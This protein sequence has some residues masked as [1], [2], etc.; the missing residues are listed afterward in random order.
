MAGSAKKKKISIIVQARMSSTR[1]PGKVLMEVC[2]KPALQHLIERLKFS[3]FAGQIILAI[4]DTQENDVL[5]KFAFNNSVG[6]YRGSENDVLGRIYLA[7]KKNNCDI[8]VEVTGDNPLIDPEIVDVAVKKH[9]KTNADYSCT[10]YKS[11]FLPIGL[12]VG[13]ISFQALEMAYRDAKE[14]Y[15]R[16]HVT[17]Y[18]YENPNIFKITG[19]EISKHLKGDDIRLTLDTKED[20]ELITKIFEKLYKPGRIFGAKEMLDLLKI[21]PELKKIN[22]HIIQKTR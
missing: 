19:I 12:D 5:E 15:N 10:N 3:K 17:S 13:V 2:G 14:V 22:S 21:E 9:I 7:S 16:E 18:F 11:K 4:P 6:C 8:V 20:M 1:L